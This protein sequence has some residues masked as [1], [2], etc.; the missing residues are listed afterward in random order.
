MD[1]VI[2]LNLAREMKGKK[3]EDPNEDLDVIE[4]IRELFREAVCKKPN[5]ALVEEE[6]PIDEEDFAKL[7]MKIQSGE[8]K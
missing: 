7:M 2:D 1:K 4:D 6:K 3:A 5:L 8:T